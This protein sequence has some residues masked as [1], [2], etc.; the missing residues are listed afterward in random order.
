MGAEDELGMHNCRTRSLSHQQMLTYF[1]KKKT[2]PCFTQD[3]KTSY[4]IASSGNTLRLI[5]IVGWLRGPK[6]HSGLVACIAV[7]SLGLNTLGAN[8]MLTGLY[9]FVF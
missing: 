4:H 1:K 3:F 5:F 9:S 6:S 7:F 8:I 2:L